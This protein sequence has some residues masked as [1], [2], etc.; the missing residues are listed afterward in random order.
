MDLTIS[1]D[2][3]E[4]GVPD[5]ATVLAAALEA[6]IYIPHL[7]HHTDLPPARGKTPAEAV[8]RAGERVAHEGGDDPH[9]GCGL[10]V[11]EVAG[12]DEPVASCDLVAS[13]GLE[14]TTDSPALRSRR[15]E[16]L[17]AILVHHPHAC[18]TCA[19]KEGCSREPCSTSVPVEERCC[20]LLGRCEFENLAAHVGVPS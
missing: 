5:G 20:P 17:A 15:Q 12:S 3:K 10:C 18:I 7:C 1:I 9:D 14:V 4:I 19:Q 13:D 6:G 16:K 2:G 11:V 8:W